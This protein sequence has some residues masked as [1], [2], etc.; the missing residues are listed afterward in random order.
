M[1]VAHAGRGVHGCGPM[2]TCVRVRVCAYTKPRGKGDY[3]GIGV[4]NIYY[5]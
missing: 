4:N 5:S 1:C 2:Y 3:R